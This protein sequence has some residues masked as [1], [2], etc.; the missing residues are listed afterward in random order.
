MNDK[1]SEFAEDAEEPS[2]TSSDP[3]ERKLA[4]QLR[5]KRRLEM[6]TKQTRTEEEEVVERTLTE[7]QIFTSSDLLEKLLIEGDEVISCVKVANDARELQR[8]GE[9]QKI[10]KVLLQKLEEDDKECTRRYKEINDKWS[11]ILVSKDPLDIHA[12]MEVQNVKC[13]EIMVRKDAVIAELRQELENADLQFINDQKTQNEDID[14]LIDRMDKQIN[15]MI[16]AYRRE[17]SLINR[18]IDSE[19]KVLLENIMEKWEAL[20]KKLKENSLAGLDKRKEIMRNYEEEMKKVIIE[21]QEEYRA[22]KITFELE[23]QKLQQEVQNTKALCFMNIEK[24]DYNYAVLKRRE[25][26]NAIVKNQQKRRL[27]KLQDVINTLRKDYAELEENTRT[28]I[29]KL[30]DQVV[31][32]RK[33]IFDLVEKSSHFTNINDKKY[34]QIWDMNMKHANELL[35]KILAADKVIYE[36]ALGMEWS[37]PKETLLRKEDLPSY[38]SVMCT[39]EEENRLA[40]EKRLINKSYKPASTIEEINLERRL[41]NHIIKLIADRCDYLIEDKLLQLLL[42][43]TA[44]DQLVIRLDNVFQALNIKSEETLGFLLNFFL[45]Y[46]Y[47][48]ICMGKD[49]SESICDESTKSSSSKT[50]IEQIDICGSPEEF[51]EDEAKLIAA[52]K[53]AICDEKSSTPYDARIISTSSRSS[54][55]ETL[56]PIAE[57]TSIS[58][59]SVSDI[60]KDD[61]QMQQRL[62]CDRGHLLE[63]ETTFVIKALQELLERYHFVKEIPQTFQEK[64]TAKK[65]IISRN[66]SIED[67][68][69]FWKRYS[70]IFSV[71][72]E[73]LWDGLLVGLK[74]YHEILKERHQLNIETESLRRQNAELR[75]LLKTY[76]IEP[77]SDSLSQDDVQLVCEMTE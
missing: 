49:K 41:L 35:D 68:T 38:C 20:Y 30:T 63:I 59:N 70:E 77:G 64:L 8:R 17:L 45:P 58:V 22:Q 72:K 29:E 12:E 52:V 14:L 13:L 50:S 23:I 65:A 10:K 36:Q 42:P 6:L 34:M 66:M 27:N 60:T 19:R 73:R 7:K 46:A 71:K 43:Y 2:V 62:L 32:A 69:N 21:N 40:V 39:I 37:L 47:C 1:Y 48:P 51:T 53:E 11:S 26:E 16:K 67:V 18:V 5:I 61:D 28:E 9:Q 25:D 74:K 76:V 75:R 55:S 54:L 15:L 33:N 56:L 3:N 57:C 31:K 4:R 44:N 24:L